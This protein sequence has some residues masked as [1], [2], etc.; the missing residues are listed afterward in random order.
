[1]AVHIPLSAKAQE[2]AITLMM[3]SQNLLKPADGS[4]I[5]LPNKE[6]AVGIFYLTSM[7]DSLR[8]EGKQYFA[9]YNDAFLAHSLKKIRLREP[10]DVKFDGKIVET[11]IGRLMLNEKLPKDF[12]FINEPIKASGIKRLVTT[13][14]KRYTSE[15]VEHII[16][17]IKSLGFYGS[18]VSGISVS[19]FDNQM[20]GQKDELIGEAGKKSQE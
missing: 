4:P 8:K 11:T 18:T 3:P 14:I 6:M 10:I 1:M 7:D 15:E 16:D 12:G 2:E 9:E 5:T 20:I 19:V 17:S 13:A